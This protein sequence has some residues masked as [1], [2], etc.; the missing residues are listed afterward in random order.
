MTSQFQV[1]YYFYLKLHFNALMNDFP[2]IGDA[3][4]IMVSPGGQTLQ[5]ATKKYIT[6]SCF[7]VKKIVFGQRMPRFA[8]IL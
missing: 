4:R 7:S 5:V 3:H 8:V 6:W 2:V 1:I